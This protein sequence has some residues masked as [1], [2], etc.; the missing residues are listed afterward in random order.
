MLPELP[1]ALII[2]SFIIFWLQAVQFKIIPFNLTLLYVGFLI[3]LPLILA[4]S[5]KGITFLKSL[6]KKNDGFLAIIFY[7]IFTA[8]QYAIL[9]VYK[10]QPF[11]FKFSYIETVLALMPY[12]LW[13]PFCA[14]GL[15]YFLFKKKTTLDID[16]R[17]ILFLSIM[18]A[19][20]KLEIPFFDFYIKKG[21]FTHFYK[22]T[23]LEFKV[24]DSWR[25][26]ELCEI[27]YL[28]IPVVL[29]MMG[30]VS[31]QRLNL[32]RWNYRTTKI[33]GYFLTF[34]FLRNLTFLHF[35][36]LSLASSS[37]MWN[38]ATSF[39]P[40][41]IKWALLEE[42]IFRGILQTWLIAKLHNLRFGDFF[43]ILLTA[44]LFGIY[45][46]PFISTNWYQATFMGAI[47]GWSYS[48]TK[49]LWVPITIHGFNNIIFHSIFVLN[50]A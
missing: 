37:W 47:F 8:F 31:H 1:A 48:K 29:V 42:T 40:A 13:F 30:A 32:K 36:D 5:P 39:Y 41:P 50:S 27:W 26:L 22:L 11:N 44:L 43:A 2:T 28:L 21:L 34:L 45:H 9:V 20:A 12:Y 16:K 14:L 18:L 35:G 24:E 10:S 4:F 25:Y 33:C 7:L 19:L 46:Y 15:S 49:N 6:Y 17:V 23:L 38:L 3:N